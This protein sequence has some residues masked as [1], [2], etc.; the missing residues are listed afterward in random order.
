MFTFSMVVIDTG[1]PYFVKVIGGG[2]CPLHKLLGG[3]G[4]GVSPLCPLPTS[5]YVTYVRL[6]VVV[7]KCKMFACGYMPCVHCKINFVIITILFVA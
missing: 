4:E 5:M 6:F 2:L 1:I 3:G 7:S